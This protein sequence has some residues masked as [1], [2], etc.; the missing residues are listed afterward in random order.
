MTG[1]FKRDILNAPV[2][3]VRNFLLFLLVASVFLTAFYVRQAV[4]S[5]LAYIDLPFYLAIMLLMAKYHGKLSLAGTLLWTVL[6]ALFLIIELSSGTGFAAT[7]KFFFLYCAPVLVCQVVFGFNTDEGRAFAGTIVK[8]V[9]VFTLLVFFILLM[10]MLTG[11]AVMRFLTTRLFNE[12]APWVPSSVFQRHPSIWGHYLMTAGYYLAFFYLNVAYARVT[13]SWLLDQRLIYVVATVGIISTGGKTVF[14]IYLVSLI[15]LNLTGR[16]G[17]RNAIAL[18]TFLLLLYWMGLFDIVLERFGATDLSSGRNDAVDAVFSVELPQLFWGYGEG[19]SSYMA[20]KVSAFTVEI[21]SEYSLLSLAFKFGV[22]FV[23]LMVVLMLRAPVMA[24]CCSGKW[25]LAFMGVLL[26]FYFSTFNA[27]NGIPDSYLLC[28]LYAI[29]VSM[30]GGFRE[31]K[32]SRE[33]PRSAKRRDP[34]RNKPQLEPCI[35]VSLQSRRSQE[36]FTRVKHSAGTIV[37]R[38]SVGSHGKR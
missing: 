31:E 4:S 36:G 7:V 26:V 30:L 21:F 29:V 11:S 15:W 3:T 37:A 12:L 8:A 16:H 32:S 10:D 9:N 35:D 14:V 24:A 18:T 19:F 27:F 34:P 1:A 28:S 25:S 22:V 13:N 17:V 38:P 2:L 5:Q 6:A 33:R 23:V 20:A